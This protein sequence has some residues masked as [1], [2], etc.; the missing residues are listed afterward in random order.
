M[1]ELDE[2][3]LHAR[4]A[5][6]A[7]EVDGLGDPTSTWQRASRRVGQRRRRRRVAS[8]AAVVLVLGLGAAATL[9]RLLDPAAPES[10]GVAGVDAPTA[11]D[12]GGSDA[13]G[14]PSSDTQ[15]RTGGAE[16]GDSEPGGAEPDDS[17]PGD[18]EVATATCRN[19]EGGFAVDYPTRWESNGSTCSQF[20]PDPDR[21]P[22]GAGVGGRKGVRVYATVYDVS[23]DV[24]RQ[25]ILGNQEVDK[26]VASQRRSVDGRRALRWESVATAQSPAPQGRRLTGWLV[27]LSANRALALTTDELDPGSYRENVEALDLMATSVRPLDD[28]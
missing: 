24:E 2:Q 12:A 4:L 23:F 6:A 21:A 18:T 14:G 10:P 13:G 22:K 11:S 16:P 7:G 15:P 27:E 25:R 3:Q 8:A 20:G 9:P 5:R 19:G 1:S 28:R 26:V 17:E